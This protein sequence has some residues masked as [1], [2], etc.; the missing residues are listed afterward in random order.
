MDIEEESKQHFSVLH[1]ACPYCG[2]T[3]LGEVHKTA[4][5]FS[6]AAEIQGGKDSWFGLELWFLTSFQG[7][8]VWALNREHLAYLID[9]LSADLREKPLGRAKKTQSDHLPTFMK[10]AKNRER[11]VKLLKKLQEK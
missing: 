8:L 4:E 6:Y 2:A 11:I 5:A 1:V 9:Y 10:T 3:M 7:K